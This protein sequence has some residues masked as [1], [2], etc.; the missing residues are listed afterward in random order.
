LIPAL[1]AALLLC[2]S[3]VR[4]PAA[5][6][7]HFLSELD[8]LP[9]PPGLTEA[10]GGVLFESPSGRIVE[11]T[12]QGELDAGQI[13]DFY[14]QTLPQLGWEKVGPSTFRRDNELLKIA[15]DTK[16]RP[17]LVHFSVVPH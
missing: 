10:P 13:L 8:D 15:V 14:A 2:A 11:A 4:T 7:G 17:L 6:E 12:A 16:R 3:P 5:A 9:L 1:L